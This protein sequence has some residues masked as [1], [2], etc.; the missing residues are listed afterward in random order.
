[1]I[2]NDHKLKYFRD[3][4][5]TLQSKFDKNYRYTDD[6]R[7]WKQQRAIEDEIMTIKKTLRKLLIEDLENFK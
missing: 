2:N 7:V 4:L 6:H 1:M 5:E 3:R